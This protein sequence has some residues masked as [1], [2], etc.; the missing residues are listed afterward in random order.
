MAMVTLTS[1]RN[2]NLS[3]TL[4]LENHH[5]LRDASFS[6]YLNDAENSLTTTTHEH[7]SLG[8]KKIEDGE[9]DVFGA[10]KYFNEGMDE[11][12]PRISDKG[13]TRYRHHEKDE[14]VDIGP[15][16]PKPQLGTQSVPS[17]SSRNS[18]SMLLHSVQRNLSRRKTNKIHRGK[19]FFA[20]LGCNCSCN[21]KDSLDIDEHACENN[22]SRGLKCGVLHGKTTGKGT[23]KTGLV[24]IDLAPINKSHMDASLKEDLNSRRGKLAVEMQSQEEEEDEP[25]KSLEVFGSPILEKGKRRN[26]RVERRLAALSWDAIPRV[27]ETEI[28]ASSVG[29]DN[30][31]ESDASSDLFEIESFTNNAKPFLARQASAGCMSGYVTPTTCYAPSE[32]SIEWTVVTASV[33]DFSVMSDSEELRTATNST[34]LNRMVPAAKTAP[35]KEIQKR[36]PSLLSCKSHKS[37]RIAGDAYRTSKTASPEP[38]RHHRSASFAPVTRFRAETKLTGIDSRNRAQSARALHLLPIH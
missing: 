14:A 19:S 2:T 36:L 7:L 16:K 5:H 4:S 24:S 18:Q 1:T 34:N 33:A 32:G 27:E 8:G 15:R 6:S 17:E 22:S 10:E 37:V 35:S 21:D 30:D 25:R 20:S 28:S 11:E 23:V 29:M 12:N 38:R 26:S 9:I 3:Q 31:T 13:A